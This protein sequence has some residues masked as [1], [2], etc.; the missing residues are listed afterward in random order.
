MNNT[1][2]IVGRWLLLAALS[3][4]APA[5]G[6][7]T[8][9]DLSAL[10]Q[11]DSGAP[12]SRDGGATASGNGSAPGDDAG[13]SASRDVRD[14]PDA[15][16]DPDDAAAA[17][18]HGACLPYEARSFDVT[19]G[20]E[21]PYSSSALWGVTSIDSPLILLRWRAAEPG[22][23]AVDATSDSIGGLQLVVR[24]GGCD[25][26]EVPYVPPDHSQADLASIPH[27]HPPPWRRALQVAAGDE[28]TF[29]VH[30]Q[31]E[32]RVPR[33]VLVR[34]DVTLVCAE[35]AEGA[36]VYGDEEGLS[37]GALAS[38]LD[39][40]CFERDEPGTADERCPDT[41]YDNERVEGCCRPDGVC[42]HLGPLLG[43]HMHAQT[44]W[45][46]WPEQLRFYCDDR[47]AP[48]PPDFYQCAQ[49]GEPCTQALDCCPHYN[50]GYA[51]CVEGLCVLPEG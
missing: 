9:P 16:G 15:G 10:P 34:V 51:S 4:S 17:S 49:E 44:G 21:E 26:V 3:V 23:Y 37:C 38:P 5:C 20:P 27:D 1:P 30:G 42:G 19:P 11:G 8:D 31:I 36:C 25:G 28:Y 41:I 45:P 48:D 32:R 50:Y 2:A 46:Y 12:R 22:L 33:P 40:V 35:G 47:A 13:G 43:C 6:D 24:V 7:D 39:P 18:S 14:D 29:E